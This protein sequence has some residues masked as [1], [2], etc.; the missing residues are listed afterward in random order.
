MV[1]LEHKLQYNPIIAYSK[2]SWP[3]LNICKDAIR[4]IFIKEKKQIQ[5]STGSNVVLKG[6]KDFSACQHLNLSRI[7]QGELIL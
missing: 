2:V 5:T 7:I 6:L 4:T 3:L 1:R